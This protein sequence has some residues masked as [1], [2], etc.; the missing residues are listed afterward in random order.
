M[1]GI[2]VNIKGIINQFK[3][4]NRV[5]FIKNIL[6]GDFWIKVGIPGR[7]LRRDVQINP[8][9]YPQLITQSVLAWSNE[10]LDK[11]EKMQTDNEMILDTKKDFE[12]NGYEILGVV[13]D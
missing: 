12:E 4:E 8:K 6:M 5:F 2:T 9:K 1:A 7:K 13:L 11:I 3:Y 10:D